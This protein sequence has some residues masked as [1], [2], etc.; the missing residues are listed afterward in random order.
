[1]AIL[2]ITGWVAFPQFS[3]KF[4]DRYECRNIAITS[5]RGLDRVQPEHRYQRRWCQ[6]FENRAARASLRRDDADKSKGG[7]PAFFTN[8]YT[9]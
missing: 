4:S 8:I 7:P 5:R 6:R 1:M 2:L 3:A 9:P